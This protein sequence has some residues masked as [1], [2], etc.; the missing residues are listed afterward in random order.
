MKEA[1]LNHLLWL[2][3][4]SKTGESANS[5]CSICLMEKHTDPWSDG[6]CR[7]GGHLLLRE[8]WKKA[9]AVL[10]A[11]FYGPW[12][13]RKGTELNSTRYC[14]RLGKVFQGFLLLPFTR[15][16][17]QRGQKRISAQGCRK[18]DRNE[19]QENAGL[20]NNQLSN[21]SFYLRA[22][23]NKLGAR[24]ILLESG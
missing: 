24:Q 21:C 17:Q 19:E 6:Q 13:Q 2:K 12:G 11:Q 23:D 16:S 14:V 9:P 7:H 22:S 3:Q 4:V 5:P 20:A 10:W 18:R 15:R 8:S 1:S